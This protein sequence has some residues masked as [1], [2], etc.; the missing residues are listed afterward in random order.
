MNLSPH[1]H[2]ELSKRFFS[3]ASRDLGKERS[4]EN[5]E[6][7]FDAL[8]MRPSPV[9][10]NYGDMQKIGGQLLDFQYAILK[11]LPFDPLIH[12]LQQLIHN[13]YRI[14]F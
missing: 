14:D 4:V 5:K 3:G 9:S 1:N 13:S 2:K 11:P 8:N 6:F 7:Y 12:H 10:G